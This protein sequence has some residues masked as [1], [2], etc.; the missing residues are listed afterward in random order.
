MDN[1]T[2]TYNIVLSANTPANATLTAIFAKSVSTCTISSVPRISQGPYPTIPAVLANQSL[3]YDCTLS[4][5]TGTVNAYVF[6]DLTGNFTRFDTYTFNYTTGDFYNPLIVGNMEL[7]FGDGNCSPTP[8]ECYM[9]FEPSGSNYLAEYSGPIPGFYPDTL[10]FLIPKGQSEITSLSSTGGVTIKVYNSSGTLLEM[11]Q[12]ISTA[13]MRTGFY[14]LDINAAGN[15]TVG[16]AGGNIVISFSNPNS[17]SIPGGSKPMAV[18][19]YMPIGQY[20]TGTGWGTSAGKFTTGTGYS[21]TGSTLGAL[22]GYIEFEFEAPI[23]NSANN[24]YGVDFVIYGNAFN[25]NPEAGAVQ[26]SADGVTWY[27]LAGSMYYDRGYRFKTENFGPSSPNTQ[28]NKYHDA[29]EGVKNNTEVLYTLAS[30]LIKAKLDNANEKTFTTATAWWPAST[31]GYPM[32]GAHINSGSNVQVTKTGDN[33]GNT[34]KFTGITAIPDYDTNAS[35]AFGYM[36]VTPNGSPNA[37]G[38]AVNPYTA[39]TS[40]KTGGD[41]FDL[42]WAVNISN[43]QPVN[44]SNL[45]IKYVRVYSAVLD[46]GTFGETS[47]EICGIFTTAN[48]QSSA[49]GR[50]QENQVNI[51]VGGVSVKDT[52]NFTKSQVGNV[53]IY[54]KKSNIASGT[55]VNVSTS[56]LGSPNKYINSKYN[57]SYQTVETNQ[58]VRVIVQDGEKEPF[59]AIIKR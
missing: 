48:A 11:G 37:Y 13:N 1:K 27:E 10:S 28:N 45:Q 18:K 54:T 4:N 22:G 19:S 21:Q 44:I 43:G 35:Y 58:T 8:P 2:Y 40:N 24:P 15:L 41:G 12:N 7:R 50:V 9:E 20:A 46:N 55:T 57:T 29:Y 33:P 30:N 17:G 38:E 32:H 59:I 26:V 16:K 5:G 39:Y 49:V 14:V 47:P 51:T 25:G 6:P 34:L 42:D 56:G 52:N 31:E 3:T 36:D 53:V 23:P